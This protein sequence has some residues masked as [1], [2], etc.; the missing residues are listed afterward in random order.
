[1][2]AK[3]ITSSFIQPETQQKLG[4]ECHNIYNSE[5]KKKAA[6]LIERTLENKSCPEIED[7]ESWVA[8]RI[9][10]LKLSG[11]DVDDPGLMKMVKILKDE[12]KA[13]IVSVFLMFLV[14]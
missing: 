12:P 8:K 3:K 1:M 13:S 7:I 14:F 6:D 4:W 11:T 5:N 10:L 2:T 9:N